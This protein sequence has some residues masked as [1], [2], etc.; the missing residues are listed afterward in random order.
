MNAASPRLILHADD[1]GMNRP[2]NEGILRGF[3]DGLLTSTSMLSGAPDAVWAIEQWKTLAD[4]RAAGRWASASARRRLDD[5]NRPFDLGIHW[6]LTQGRPL[7]A[8]RYPAE[9][10]DSAGRFPGVGSLF[11]RLC[12]GGEKYL[13]PIR[14]ELERQ[15]EVICDHSLRPTHLNGHQYIEMIPAIS[16]LV[17]DAMRR[18]GISAVRV[19]REP[20]LFRTTAL[21]GFQIG[22][23]PL[24]LVK[25]WFAGRF[26]AVADANGLRHTEAFFGTAHAGGIDLALLGRFL[27]GGRRHRLVEIAL[28]PGQSPAG[29]SPD[30][31]MDGA[32]DEEADG[33]RDPLADLRPGELQMLVSGE[34]PKLLESAGWRL[35]RLAA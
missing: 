13:A 14:A 16:S 32:A 9:L 31:K 8:D 19:A 7:T 25:R 20:A 23:W 3:R 27:S 2:V 5:P 11:L 22:K 10:L 33:W 28:H 17:P 21:N 18:F 15:I 6:N 12:R 4:Q 29:A 35:G 34:L 30:E 24:A 26:L 1:F